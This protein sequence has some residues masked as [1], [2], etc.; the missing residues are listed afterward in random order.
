MSIWVYQ[1][2]RLPSPAKCRMAIRYRE[3]VASAIFLR[4]LVLNPFSRAATSRLAGS[5]LSSP[6][7][8]RGQRLIEV[9]YVEDQL[10]LGRAEQ[11]EVGQVRVTAGLDDEA[12]G[13][14]TGQ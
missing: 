13:R 1:T 6:L 5:P 10:S 3:T 12:G 4:S 9:V 14:R 7:P 11:P 2:S 8:R